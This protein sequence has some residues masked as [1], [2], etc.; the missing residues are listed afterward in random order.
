MK[1]VFDKNNF[2]RNN[3]FNTLTILI[4][5]IHEKELDKLSYP[6]LISSIMNSCSNNYPTKKELYGKMYNLYNANLV[7]FN[8]N[9]YKN[10][11]YNLAIEI[12]NPK[13]LNDDSLLDD[14]FQLAK[15]LI[16]NPLLNDKKDGF[17]EKIFSEKKRLIIDNIKNIYNDKSRYSY[18]KLL[19]NMKKEN[20]FPISNA[21]DYESIEKVSNNS[22]YDYYKEIINSSKVLVSCYGDIE[23]EVIKKYIN[24]LNLNTVDVN[25]N[26]FEKKDYLIEKVNKIEEYQN[27]HQAKLHIGYRTTISYDS[28]LYSS[29]VVFSVMFGGMFN[30]TLTS[31]I[32]EKLSLVYS[33]YSSIIQDQKIFVV[34]SGNDYDKTDEIVRIVNEELLK[35]QNGDIENKEALLSMAK[36]SII[37]ETKDNFDS[38]SRT[39]TQKLKDTLKGFR[40]I[41]DFLIEIENVSIDDVI[42]ASK[43]LSLDT[44]YVLG[45]KNNE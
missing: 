43:T 2:I 8:T 17:D 35:Y 34:S 15:E 13:Y 9:M 45:G 41:N 5:F 25:I 27:L 23:E 20:E 32:R 19:E 21:L 16:Y 24:D 18:I 14:T 38:A 11:A 31:N 7:F 4:S 26:L 3:K 12:V 6:A 33:I 37:N 36:E 28:S 40:N 39:L 10:F 42:K 1:Y 30:S 44:I 29:Y 22:L